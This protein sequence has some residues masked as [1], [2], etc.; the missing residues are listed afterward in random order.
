VQEEKRSIGR[1]KWE[2][3]ITMDLPEVGWKSMD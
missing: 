1:F 2:N 3:N